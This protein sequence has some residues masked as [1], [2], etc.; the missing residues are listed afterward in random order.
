MTQRCRRI[1]RDRNVTAHT[2]CDRYSGLSPAPVVRAADFVK[3][4]FGKNGDRGR[5]SLGERLDK[6]G[7]S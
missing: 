6:R 7:L 1:Q 3:E 5:A 4:V 2:R